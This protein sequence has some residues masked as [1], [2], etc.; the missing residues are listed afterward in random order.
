[1]VQVASFTG[2]RLSYL[3]SSIADLARDYPPALAALEERR[4]QAQ[5]LFL[6][7]N[8]DRKVASELNALNRAL[9]EDA[10]TLALY[11][12]LPADDSR[13]KMLGRALHQQLIAAQRYA[14]ALSAE[15]FTVMKKMWPGIMAIE[16][17]PRPANQPAQFRQM[18]HEYCI[19]W[20]ATRL[21]VL[22]GAG[23]LDDARELLAT[24]L[25]YDSSAEART[26]YQE[27]LSRAGHAD[28][29]PQPE[30]VATKG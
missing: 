10:K 5:A 30:A 22:A 3:L 8:S 29:L 16:Q 12:Q 28:L 1:M 6:G 27:Q 14:D 7:G 4:D 20:I 2:V 18:D 17:Q 24:A 25:A 9:K 11:D 15:P 13:R 19:R 26:H 23:Q 21:E